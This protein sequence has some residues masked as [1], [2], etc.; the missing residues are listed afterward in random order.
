MLNLDPYLNFNGQRRQAME[1]YRS[2]L[3]GD[4]QFSTYQETGQYKKDEE[5]NLIMH[6]VLKNDFLTIYAADGKEEHKVSFGNSVHLSIQGDDEE[7][8]TGFF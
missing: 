2:V 7:K 6:S 8:L 3:G 4:L 5:K 1:F